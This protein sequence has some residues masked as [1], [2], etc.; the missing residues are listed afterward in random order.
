MEK[1]EDNDKKRTF[2]FWK[3]ERKSLNKSIPKFIGYNIESGFVELT[4][5]I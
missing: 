4:N 2:W 5:N 1:N 3:V